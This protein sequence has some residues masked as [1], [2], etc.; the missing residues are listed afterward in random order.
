ML[1]DGVVKVETVY[2]EDAVLHVLRGEGG[3]K[4]PE[5]KD[6][7]WPGEAPLSTSPGDDELLDGGYGYV[8]QAAFLH[9][10]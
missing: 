3:K 6:S 9:C 8:G 4:I 2:Q 10:S 7:G 1:I 5:P